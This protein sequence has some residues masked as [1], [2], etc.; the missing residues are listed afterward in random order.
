MQRLSL[1]AIGLEALN[2]PDGVDPPPAELGVIT[3]T[4]KLYEARGYVSP[5]VC[6]LAVAGPKCVGTCG[7][8]SPPREGEVE[9]AYF[10]FPEEE[11]RLRAVRRSPDHSLRRPL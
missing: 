3:A 2:L 1:H 8:T 10:T 11:G 4:R 9:I 5:W 7:F 6:Y